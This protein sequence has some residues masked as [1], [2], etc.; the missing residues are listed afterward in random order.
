MGVKIIIANGANDT[1]T[2]A[3]L[4]DHWRGHHAGLVKEHLAPE[5]YTVTEL[6]KANR[7]YHG[8]AVLH[9]GAER[10]GALDQPPPEIQAD[11]FYAMIGTRT[12]MR[13]TEH[14]IV[15][16]DPA[17]D[18]F[19]V[20]AFV[21]RAPDVTAARFFDHW[22]DAHAPNVAEHLEATDGALRYVVN[23]DLDA[24]DDALF[25]GVAELWYRDADASKAHLGAVPD[26]GFN[27]LT[28]DG[29]FLRG[30]EQ[31]LIG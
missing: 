3:Q 31:V 9:L 17:P 23:H 7:G 28:S 4:L 13:V 14:V 10:A 19:K 26:D 20:T 12:V 16:G 8:I 21:R 22:L 18:G 15:D 25:H 30:N 1:V 5:R 29:L 27:A 2:P 11:P 6:V 24:P